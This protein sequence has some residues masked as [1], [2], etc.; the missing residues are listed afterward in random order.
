M[1]E[2]QIGKPKYP[3]YLYARNW[4]YVYRTEREMASPFGCDE[5]TL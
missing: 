2:A 1:E 4:L 3:Y 5:M